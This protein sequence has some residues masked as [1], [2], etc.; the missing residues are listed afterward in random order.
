MIFWIVLVVC[1]TIYNVTEL[2][3]EYKKQ[4]IRHQDEDEE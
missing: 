2:Y 3:F 1:V 4:L